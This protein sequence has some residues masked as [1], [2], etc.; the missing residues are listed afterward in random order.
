MIGGQGNSNCPEPPRRKDANSAKEKG[1]HVGNWRLPR[2]KRECEVRKH[3]FLQ[4]GGKTSRRRD[5]FGYSRR[6]GDEIEDNEK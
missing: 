2:S 6:K 1:S 4:P 5:A 3:L